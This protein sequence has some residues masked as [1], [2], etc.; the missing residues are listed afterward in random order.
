MTEWYESDKG[1]ALY[2]IES[3]SPAA[4]ELRALGYRVE[5]SEGPTPDCLGVPTYRVRCLCVSRAEWERALD[6]MPF[7]G[8]SRAADWW[9]DRTLSDLLKW[10]AEHMPCW[11]I[12]DG[13][14]E[15]ADDEA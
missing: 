10:H 11:K 9:A 8:P 12:V 13:E 5:E 14:T 1:R 6:F 3:R 7:L 4:A 2:G 15:A